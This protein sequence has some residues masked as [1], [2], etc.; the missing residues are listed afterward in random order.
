MSEAV[1][2]LTSNESEWHAARARCLAFIERHYGEGVVLQPYL[3]SF[4]PA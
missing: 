1:S 4:R 2:W 3:Q